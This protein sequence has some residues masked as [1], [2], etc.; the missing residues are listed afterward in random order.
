MGG[1][2]LGCSTTYWD[3]GYPVSGIERCTRGSCR[4]LGKAKCLIS[5]TTPGVLW[6]W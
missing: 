4:T 1:L 6:T 5:M 2:G 3:L